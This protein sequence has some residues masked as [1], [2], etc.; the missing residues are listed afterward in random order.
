M[1]PDLTGRVVAIT[2]GAR[3]IGAASAQA[4]TAAGARV[5]VGDIDGA[6][7]TS[8]L[9]LDVTD[10]RSFEAFLTTVEDRLGPIDVLVNNAGIMPTGPFLQEDVATTDQ[11]LDINV[12]GVITGCRLAGRLFAA[13]GHGHLINLAS[14]AG[15]SAYPGL[16]TYCASKY[17][18]VGLTEALYRELQPYGVQVTAILPGIVRTDLSAGT[19]TTRWIE[20]LSTVDA[21]DVAA[22]IVGAV[23]RPRPMVTVPKRLAVTI[24]AVSLMPRRLRMAVER[25]TG[26]PAAFT[27]AD[28]AAR[29]RYHQ[30]L[31]EQG[32]LRR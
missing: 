9:S 24:H 2:G 5:A 32:L 19:K 16:A 13:R 11:V 12:G 31:R 20:A 18:V 7:G 29:E 4:L 1:A 28:P 30:R 25:A 6:L 8:V 27:Q 17:A 21:D 22:A 23:A 14:L 10:E 15:V 3:G 26:A